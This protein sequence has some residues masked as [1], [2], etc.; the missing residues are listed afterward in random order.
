[1]GYSPPAVARL[2]LKFHIRMLEGNRWKREAYNRMAAPI[3]LRWYPDQS[4]TLGSFQAFDVLCA[5]FG[6][7]PSDPDKRRA[8]RKLFHSYGLQPP[9]STAVFPNTMGHQTPV[10]RHRDELLRLLKHIKGRGKIAVP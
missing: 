9:L 8:A 3:E 10:I 1:V 4:G 5:A 6:W 2:P 7:D